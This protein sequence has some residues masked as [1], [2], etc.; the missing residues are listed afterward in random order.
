MFLAGAVASVFGSVVG[1][2][3]AF[4]VIPLLRLVFGFSPTLASGTSLIFV[5]ANTLTASVGFLRHRRVDVR[6]ATYLGAAAL[7][8]S[9]GGAFLT[10][11]LSPLGFDAGYGTLLVILAIATL[12]RRNIDPRPEGERTFLHTPWAAIPTGLILGF[13]SSLF[14]IGGGVVVLPLM[15]MAARM[16][17]HVAA[18][19]SSFVILLTAPVGVLIHGLHGEIAWLSAIPIILGGLVGGYVAPGIA[20]RVSSP[21]LIN[22]MALA[23]ILAACGLVLR[24]V[25]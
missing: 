5:L 18:A 23:F 20:R 25:F 15:L 2:G 12:L 24:H 13:S 8:A 22:L 3:G 4:V 6:L 19:T 16:P 9:I 10:R 1:L 14:G 21:Q 11:F 7:P 17:A